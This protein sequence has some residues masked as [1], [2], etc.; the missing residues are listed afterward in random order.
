MMKNYLISERQFKKIVEQVGGSEDK[1]ETSKDSLNIFTKMF[2][3]SKKEVKPEDS[4]KELGDSDP[5]QQFFN[6][7]K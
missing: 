1:K 2:G 5:I 7:L 6:S 4:D 3:G